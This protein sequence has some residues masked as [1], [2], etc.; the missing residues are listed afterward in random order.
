MRNAASMPSF[1]SRRSHENRGAQ[2]DRMKHQILPAKIVIVGGSMSGSADE[3]TGAGALLSR[4]GSGPGGADRFNIKKDDGD[5][6]DLWVRLY[7]LEF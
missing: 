3:A 1:E 6:P 2:D 4:Q 7:R 5:E